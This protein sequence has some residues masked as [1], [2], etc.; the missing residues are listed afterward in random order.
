[1][2]DNR[3]TGAAFYATTS[4]QRNSARRGCGPGDY[5]ERRPELSWKL[6]QKRGASASSPNGSTASWSSTTRRASWRTACRLTRRRYG[7]AATAAA[8][9]GRSRRGWRSHPRR[10]RAR[11]RRWTNVASWRK[12]APLSRDIRGVRRRS[13]SPG[14][15][16]RRSPRRLSTR[17]RSE[18]PPR[19]RR[20]WASAARSQPGP[21]TPLAARFP[22]IR[23]PTLS[24]P[25]AYAIAA[26]RARAP[27]EGVPRVQAASETAASAR[28]TGSAAAGCAPRAGAWSVPVSSLQMTFDAIAR[29]ELRRP[30][31]GRRSRGSYDVPSRP[32]AIFC[33]SPDSCRR[34]GEGDGD[35][36]ADH[37]QGR[38][39]TADRLPRSRPSS[40]SIPSGGWTAARSSGG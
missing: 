7:S 19:R 4:R 12:D 3:E 32:G 22:S 35:D 14:S 33:G 25:R 30:S 1:M 16:E 29:L 36:R 15:A 31:R 20:I 17:Q 13:G 21:V 18:P 27:R 37:A 28:R 23:S 38:R 26:R 2:L 10:W 24:A 39:G 9:S 5:S 11:S 8:R 6:D 40:A 34:I